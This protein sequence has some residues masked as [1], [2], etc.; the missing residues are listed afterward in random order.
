VEVEINIEE[1]LLYDLSALQD[2][3]DR[4]EAKFS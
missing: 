3:N 1:R 4:A 2:K